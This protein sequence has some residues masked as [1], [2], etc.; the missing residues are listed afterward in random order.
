MTVDARWAT[1]R[2]VRVVVEVSK[3]SVMLGDVSPLLSTTDTH[4][5]S[6]DSGR[7]VSRAVGVSKVDG[8]RCV[9]EAQLARPKRHD[10]GQWQSTTA[11]T[12]RRRRQLGK[13]SLCDDSHVPPTVRLRFTVGAAGEIA[14]RDGEGG[15]WVVCW[16]VEARRDVHQEGNGGTDAVKG[17]EMSK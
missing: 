17:E 3:M 7:T 9:G 12:T 14:R 11:P 6:N 16:S 13:T 8:C 1:S 4:F 2:V 10:P 15:L 5:V